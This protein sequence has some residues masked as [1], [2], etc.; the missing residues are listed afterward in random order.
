MKSSCGFS[1]SGL[2][3]RLAIFVLLLAVAIGAGLYLGRISVSI[4]PDNLPSAQPGAPATSAK[5]DASQKDGGASEKAILDQAPLFLHINGKVQE[6][7][8][9][10]QAQV[11]LATNAGFNHF[12]MPVVLN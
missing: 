8:E 7:W 2:V 11:T 12:A 6:N 4:A 1:H 5:P 3:A 10:T 9:V